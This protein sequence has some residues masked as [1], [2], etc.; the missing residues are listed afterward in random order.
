MNPPAGRQASRAMEEREA[1][2]EAREYFRRAYEL[3]MRGELEGA[4][5]YYKRSIELYPTAEAHT[6]LGWTYSFTNRYDEAIEECQ[7]AIAIDPEFGNPWNDI[8][9]YLIEKDEAH[10]ATPYL[11]R[12]IQAK[13]YESRCFPWANLARIWERAGCRFKAVECYRRALGESPDYAVAQAALR[14]LEAG[15]MN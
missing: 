5:A 1:Q 2:E 14:G 4:I 13:R 15:L 6:F 8:G 3:Q 7:K 9:V 12:A 10:K 11:M